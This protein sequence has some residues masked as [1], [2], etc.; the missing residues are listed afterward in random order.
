MSLQRLLQECI[1]ENLI[2]FQYEIYCFYTKLIKKLQNLHPTTF[3][4]HRWHEPIRINRN[5]EYGNQP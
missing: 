1:N 3:R 5:S 4:H 2:N